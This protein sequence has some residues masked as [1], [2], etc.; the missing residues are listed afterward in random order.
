V[1][2]GSFARVTGGKCR[3]S[4]ECAQRRSNNVG[5]I[6]RCLGQV[7]GRRRMRTDFVITKPEAMTPLRIHMLR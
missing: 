5:C 1:C 6:E 2:F 3:A 7:M 4:T